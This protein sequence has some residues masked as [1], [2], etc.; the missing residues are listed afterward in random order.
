[1]PASCNKRRIGWRTPN[2]RIYYGYTVLR[3]GKSAIATTLNN[4]FSRMR[5]CTKVVAKRDF[6]DRRDPRCIWRTLASNLASL[7]VGL[8]GSIMETL[9]DKSY[10]S[11]T[12]SVEDQFR[13]L[14]AKAMRN[15]QFLS[16]VVVFDAL[17][18]CFTE[19]NEH[20]RALLKT[21]A[22]WADLPKS[23]RLVITSRDIPDIRG[24]LAEIS[25][26]IS[27]TTGKDASTDAKSDTQLFFGE[28]FKEMLKDIEGVTL[29]TDWLD[30]KVIRRLTEYAAGSFIWA[31]MVVEWV[32]IDPVHRRLD[33]ILN[34]NEVSNAGDVDIL[35]GRMLF[36]VLGPLHEKERKVS[37]F[38]I[39]TI[40]LAKDPVRKSDL[41]ELLS[42]K[43]L[44][45]DET[46]RSVGNVVDELR[47]IISMDDDQRLR[48]PHKSFSDFL[49]D[50]D[51]SLAAMGCFVPKDQELPSYLIDRG[52]CSA[53]IAIACMRFLNDSLTFNAC[54]ISTSHRL[55]DEIPELDELISKNIST[56]LIYACR[57]WAMHLRD[58]FLDERLLLAVQPLLKTLLHEKVLYWLEVLSLVKAVPSAEESLLSAADVLEVRGL[59]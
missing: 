29:H 51:R 58:S 48:I 9:S 47:S 38:I 10:Y 37:R 18:E 12:A 5:L 14:I 30:E 31:K 34:G 46:R 25:H 39:A 26:P 55:N 23:F 21:V 40:V 1:M 54:G 4:E 15:Q 17:D 56:A 53:N 2:Y 20:W 22:G 42:S 19:D 11:Q 32:K 16:V 8:K 6:A 13:D 7:H 57:F 44:S 50:H 24:A 59:L 33:D 27:L 3:A 45:V 35:Y 36:D 52:E 28:K 49:L 41:V 43:Q